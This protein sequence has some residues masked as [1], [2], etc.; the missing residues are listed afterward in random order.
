MRS[1]CCCLANQNSFLLFL[2]ILWVLFGRDLLKY[3]K[4]MKG[5]K[6]IVIALVV[7]D[8]CYVPASEVDTHQQPPI[9]H[10]SRS[11]MSQVTDV[12]GHQHVSLN[13]SDS[14]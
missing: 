9:V 11:L 12:T 5:F 7:G 4:I 1:F 3:M 13:I 2:M 10:T 8:P 14:R 6:Q